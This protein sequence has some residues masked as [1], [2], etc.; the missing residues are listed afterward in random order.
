MRSLGAVSVSEGLTQPKTNETEDR[1]A[2]RI[3][4]RP[5]IVDS[6]TRVIKSA[7][8]RRSIY[9][10]TGFYRYFSMHRAEKYFYTKNLSMRFIALD[11]YQ[12][13]GPDYIVCDAML[14]KTLLG[15]RIKALRNRLRLTQ[16]QLSEAVQISPKY[17]SNIERGKENPTLDTLLRLAESLKVEVWEMFL[18]DQEM[19]DAQTLRKKIDRLLQEADTERLRLVTKLL[20]AALH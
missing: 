12:E 17:L 9:S 7:G 3:L 2:A 20:Q 16:D 19:P 18:T 11:G 1:I 5:M 4:K 8:F 14:A 6:V 13:T 10:M 15:K